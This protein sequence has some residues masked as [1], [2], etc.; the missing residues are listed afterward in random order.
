MKKEEIHEIVRFL[1]SKTTTQTQH[2]FFLCISEI[3]KRCLKELNMLIKLEN[4]L[5]DYFIKF[6]NRDLYLWW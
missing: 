1:L 4:L 3:P 5:D 2:L 6:V